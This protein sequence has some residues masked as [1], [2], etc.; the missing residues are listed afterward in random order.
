MVDK[1]GLFDYLNSIN[2]TKKDF[3]DFDA[4]ACFVINRGLSL[5]RDTCILANE[6]NC[7]PHLDKKAQFTF[8]KETV[9]KKKRFGKWPKK[10]KSDT[11]ELV[12]TYFNYSDDKA[13]SVLPLLSKANLKY[14]KEQLDE[15]G[16]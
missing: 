5:F 7:N 4:Y 11:L 9:R 6:M 13:N 16:R 2:H 1:I 8:L 10:V 15:G 3:D 14:M 12:K